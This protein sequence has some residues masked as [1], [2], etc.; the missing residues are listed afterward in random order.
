MA[1]AFSNVSFSSTVSGSVPSGL[2]NLQTAGTFSLTLSGTDAGAVT[3]TWSFAGSYNNHNPYYPNSGS[4][5][6][7]G[8]V[9]GSGGQNGPWNLTITGKGGESQGLTLSFANGE[10]TLGGQAGFEVV[11][12]ATSG[13]DYEVTYHDHYLFATSFEVAGAGPGGAGGTD[14]NDNLVGTALGD[15]ILGLAGNDTIAGGAGNYT[16]D[17][18][19]GIDTAV[20]SGARADYTVSHN[21][22]TWTVS[23]TGSDGVDTLT[24]VERLQFSD[25]KLALDVDGNA[26]Q[27]YRLYKA[28][29]DREP[30]IPG[31]GYQMN[32]LD[33]GF[34]LAQVASAFI[35]SPEFQA[36]YGSNIDDTT[37]IT[38]L[39]N[40][41][42][43]RAPDADGLQFHLNEIASGQT[44]ADVLGHFSESPENKANVIGLIENGMVYTF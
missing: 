28:A 33:Q 15:S 17:G 6:I 30:D 42:L 40:N 41:L 2:G 36:K 10:W 18:G 37:F 12:T 21:G 19:P 24:N 29:F 8:T 31:L 43:D 7:S 38:L 25:T 27:A 11:Y 5:S 35:A 14:G 13:Y 44:R 32:Q 16:V 22:S 20:F 34:T 23:H 39:Y 4:L 3:G 1:M 9:S 26:G